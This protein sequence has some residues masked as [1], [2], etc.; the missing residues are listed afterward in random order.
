MTGVNLKI[1][2]PVRAE[3][4]RKHSQRDFVSINSTCIVLVGKQFRRS[5][6]AMSHYV[7]NVIFAK[8]FDGRKL[9][10]VVSD[11]FKPL[12]LWIILGFGHAHPRIYIKI[13][14]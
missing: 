5:R 7:Q 4:T 14:V 11:P 2:C 10:P 3:A 1:A 12:A 13:L 6:R 9:A 8:S